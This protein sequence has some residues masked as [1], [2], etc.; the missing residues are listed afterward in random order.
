M[1]N[2]A[3]KCDFHYA[4]PT[5]KMC[6]TFWMDVSRARDRLFTLCEKA[7]LGRVR[8]TEETT[9]YISAPCDAMKA[10]IESRIVSY[11]VVRMGNKQTKN[12]GWIGG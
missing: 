2:G 5:Y 12:D 4:D 9:H 6:I 11:N 10:E 7:R 8:L 1:L 3:S